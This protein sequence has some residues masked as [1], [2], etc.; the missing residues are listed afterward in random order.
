ML[1]RSLHSMFENGAHFSIYLIFA[2]CVEAVLQIQRASQQMQP[3]FQHIHVFQTQ[4]QKQP[5]A[6][7][8]QS[9]TAQKFLTHAH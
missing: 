4:M 6:S 8:S 9:Q 1:C 5:A 2:E 7:Q 3:F